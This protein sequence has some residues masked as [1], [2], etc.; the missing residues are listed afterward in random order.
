ML[1]S[2]VWVGMVVL[3]QWMITTYIGLIENMVVKLTENVKQQSVKSDSTLY[4]DMITDLSVH[5]SFGDLKAQSWTHI[6]H[7]TLEYLL[8]DVWQ[9]AKN[10]NSSWE[11]QLKRGNK[12]ISKK[13]VSA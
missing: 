12:S 13:C 10:K 11:A 4:Q 5:K 9:Y 6:L 3:K 1:Y 7:W 8:I 2:R